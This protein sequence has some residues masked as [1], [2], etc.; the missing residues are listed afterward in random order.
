M[1]RLCPGEN[2]Y[3]AYLSEHGGSSN[4]YTSGT[5]TCYYF[6]VAHE[7]VW[8]SCF[9][10]FCFCYPEYLCAP[11]R[12]SHSHLAGALD[13]FSQFFLAPL[14]NAEQTD[15]EINAVHSEHS[16]NVNMDVWRINMLDKH[17]ADPAHPYHKFSTGNRDT[18]VDRPAEMVRDDPMPPPLL[19][20]P[21]EKYAKCDK[22]VCANLGNRRP[23]GLTRL[24]CQVL[25]G[26]H[27]FVFHTFFLDSFFP[28]QQ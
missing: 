17:T 1:S 10:F 27:Q 21:I 14:F 26:Q 3:S 9:F 22:F 28:S 25:F 19:L 16:K 23:F 24:P 20:A 15:R 12:P 18:L 6:N 7:Y 2:D 11:S 5:R 4:A 8:H 13:R